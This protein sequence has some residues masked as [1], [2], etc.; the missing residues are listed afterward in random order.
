VTRYHEVVRRWAILLG[1]W[2]S[3]AIFSSGAIWLAWQMLDNT[4]TLAVLL[5]LELPVWFFWVAAT[6]AIVR[7][8]RRHPLDR[9]RPYTSIGLHVVA[10]TVTAT[11]FVSFRLLWYQAF[12]P[13]PYTDQFVARWF[14]RMFREHFVGG[15]TSYWA[16]VGV[17]HAFTNYSRFRQRDVEATLV[18]GQLAEARLEALRLQLRPHFLFNALNTASA[19]LEEN[20]RRARRI[21][22][23][24]GELLRASLRTDARHLV[25]LREEAALV[26][27]YLEIEKERFGDR[28]TYDLGPGLDMS[29]V[30]VPSF[31]LQPVVENAVRHGIAPREGPGHITVHASRFDTHVEIHVEDDGV[32]LGPGPMREGIGLSNTRRRLRELYQTPDALTLRSRP[33]GGLD[34]SIR[35]PSRATGARREDVA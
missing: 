4:T 23:Q 10:A 8:S 13:A 6:V 28:L 22:G 29:D 26:A 2:A 31:I 30:L 27:S 12:N 5:R 7:L 17:Y 33:G 19:V 24:L 25:S 16:V 34:V 14:W 9:A 32:G 35:V 18:R 20:P 15:F 11:L 1:A 21:I 3:V